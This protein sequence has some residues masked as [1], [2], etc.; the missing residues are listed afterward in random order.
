MKLI[1]KLMAKEIKALRK[2]I[3]IKC[4]ENASLSGNKNLAEQNAKLREIIIECR[5]ENEQLSDELNDARIANPQ[6]CP[7]IR[8]D[9]MQY[10]EDE[11]SR[12]NN[13]QTI[14]ELNESAKIRLSVFK[15]ILELAGD[16][17]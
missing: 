8:E 4:Q 2:Q 13:L 12:L 11:I 3:K 17:K 14:S 6:G 10:I 1:I 7:A 16:K 5:A 9:I 15:R